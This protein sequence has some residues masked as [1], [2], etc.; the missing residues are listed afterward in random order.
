MPKKITYSCD[1]DNDTSFSQCNVVQHLAER[2]I[3]PRYYTMGAKQFS[4]Q[5]E[6][7]SSAHACIGVF[8]CSDY[9]PSFD[10][11]TMSAAR[12]VYTTLVVMHK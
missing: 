7:L 9:D 12:I 8:M 1:K 5:I 6:P 10:A 3:R 2:G 4:R 11:R